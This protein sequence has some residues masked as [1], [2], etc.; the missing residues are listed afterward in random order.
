MPGGH[1]LSLLAFAK[2]ACSLESKARLSVKDV[3]ETP[4]T[5][6]PQF[7]W[8]RSKS[9]IYFVAGDRLLRLFKSDSRHARSL[10]GRAKMISRDGMGEREGGESGLWQRTL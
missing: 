1:A 5:P 10:D 8:Q 9:A 7:L 2:V 3:S 6:F 4:C